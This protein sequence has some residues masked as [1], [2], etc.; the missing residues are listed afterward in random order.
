[1]N[2][3]RSKIDMLFMGHIMTK[4]CEMMSS[5]HGSTS[6]SLAFSPEHLDLYGQEL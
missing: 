1:M 4:Q 2:V 6:L 3:F 5:C